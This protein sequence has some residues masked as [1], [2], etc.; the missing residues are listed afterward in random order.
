[1]EMHWGNTKRLGSN[2]SLIKLGD[3]EK[4]KRDF[5]RQTVTEMNMIIVIHYVNVLRECIMRMRAMK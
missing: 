2:E 3:N 4:K 1:M 5:S